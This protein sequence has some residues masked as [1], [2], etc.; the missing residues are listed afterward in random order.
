[1]TNLQNPPPP[2]RTTLIAGTRDL[3]A[4]TGP[5]SYTGAGFRPRSAV[6]FFVQTSTTLHGHGSSDNV[7]I[8][9]NV[10]LNSAGLAN[11]D[12][13]SLMLVIP[14]SGNYQIG[15]VTSWDADGLTI[16]WTKTLLPTGSVTF[17]LELM[18]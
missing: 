7:L 8:Q 1:M 14:A 10:Y 16:T 9:N 4:A 3:T 13:T 2:L 11:Y 12:S 5:V 15:V 18:E 6:C 17:I